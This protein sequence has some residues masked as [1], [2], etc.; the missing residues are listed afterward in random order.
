M[1]L[2]PCPYCG[3]KKVKLRCDPFRGLYY[4]DCGR[5]FC[6]R[7]EVSGY[8]SRSLTAKAWNERWELNGVKGWET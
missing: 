2:K 4:V 3:N 5:Y 7:I 1:K 6:N 8:P